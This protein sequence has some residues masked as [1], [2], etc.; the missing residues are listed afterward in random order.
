VCERIEGLRL[1][2]RVQLHGAVPY[3]RIP[4]HFRRASVCVNASL[5]GSVDKV[6]LEAMA[7]ERLVLSCNDSFPR[8]VASLGE[9]AKALF[10]PAGDAPAL[11]ARLRVLLDL[12]PQQRMELGRE[13]RAIVARDHEVD[14]L[15]ARLVD[16]ME[17][18]P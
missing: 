9:R 8:V 2:G 17:S 4:E 18:R 12:S 10:F 7:C 5:T 1:G 16:L 15:I 13:L 14:G 3:L 6:V 11:A